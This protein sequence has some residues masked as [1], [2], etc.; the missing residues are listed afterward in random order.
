MCAKNYNLSIDTS[1]QPLEKIAD[2]IIE[3]SRRHVEAAAA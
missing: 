3:L 1:I 2:L